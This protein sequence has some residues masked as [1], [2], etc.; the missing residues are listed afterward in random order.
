MTSMA[1]MYLLAA[2]L[3]K[4][5]VCDFLL[6]AHPYQYLNKGIYGHPGGLLHSAIHGFG[7]L[8]V[9]VCF[10]PVSSTPLISVLIWVDMITHYHID[11][12]KVKV[13]RKYNL[14]PD[15]SEWFWILLGFDQ[16]L[17]MAVYWG[18]IFVLIIN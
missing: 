1:L 4:H 9:L 6:Q 8:L 17:H 16:L 18:I 15:N 14:K 7:M 12:A 2:I 13:A 11:W 10:M 5:F 3:V